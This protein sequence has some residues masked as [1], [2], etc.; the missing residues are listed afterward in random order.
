M[1]IGYLG[2]A[3]NLGHRRGQMQ[4]AVDTLPDYGV[5]VLDSSPIYDIDH[6]LGF[7]IQQAYLKCVVRIETEL[8]PEELFDAI[9]QIELELNHDRYDPRTP[10]RPIDLH[11]LLLGDVVHESPRLRIPHEEILAKGFYVIPLLDV[12]FDVRTPDGERI[13]DWLPD[14]KVAEEYRDAGGPLLVD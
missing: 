6:P 12:D 1:R 11:V 13:A 9:L 3:S 5:R 2:I 8:E 4:V 10:P 14:L 7:R